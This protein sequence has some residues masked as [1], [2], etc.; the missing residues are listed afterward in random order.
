MEK[1]G[2]LADSHRAS[3]NLVNNFPQTLHHLP[4]LEH[5]QLLSQS[6]LCQRGLQELVE[7]LLSVGVVIDVRALPVPVELSQRFVHRS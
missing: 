5:G 6:Q 4:H 1:V 7:G 3:V 2:Q